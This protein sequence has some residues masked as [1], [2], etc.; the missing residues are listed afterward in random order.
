LLKTYKQNSMYFF[1]PEKSCEF[2]IN[3]HGEQSFALRLSFKS[4]QCWS[5]YWICNWPKTAL[6]E[7]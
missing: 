3:G 7:N 5:T 2:S 1:K 4:S 6:G